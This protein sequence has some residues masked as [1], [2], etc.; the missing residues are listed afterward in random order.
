MT[1]HLRCPAACL[2]ALVA[3]W[4]ARETARR[5]APRAEAAEADAEGARRYRLAALRDE[6]GLIDPR[7]P[8]RARRRLAATLGGAFD[9][10]SAWSRAWL[11]RGPTNRSGRARALVVHPRDPRVMWTATGSGGVWKTTDAGTSW[12]PLTDAIGLPSGCL[13]S[14]PHDADHLYWGTGERYHTGGPGAG[15]WESNDGGETWRVLPSTSAWGY[16]HQIVLS[17]V[18][19]NLI[20]VSRPDSPLITSSG[21]Y[22]STDRGGTWTS[23]LATWGR[24]FDLVLDPS[25]PNRLVT[26]TEDMRPDEP[27]YD[28]YLSTDAGATWIKTNTLT[29][30]STVRYA[31]AFAPSKPS[32]VY[33]LGSKGLL[34]SQDGG[35]TFSQRSGPITLE[36]PVSYATSIWV[37][38][39]DPDILFG[40]G[41]R[42]HRSTDGGA[43]FS[44]VAYESVS[45]EV[46][47]PDHQALVSEPGFD[48]RANSRLYVL[49]DGGIDVIEDALAPAIT[50]ALARGLDA[51]MQTTEV[52]RTA[53]AAHGL[54]LTAVQDSGVL[55]IEAPRTAA[56]D[57]VGGDG[58]CAVVDPQQPAY[59]YGC[60]QGLDIWRFRADGTRIRLATTLPD[61]SVYRIQHS[62]NRSNFLA[63]VLLDPSA[64]SRMLAGGKSLWRSENVRDATDQGPPVWTEIKPALTAPPAFFDA[65]MIL[66]VAIAPSDSNLLFVA[67][68]S[69]LVFR[70]RNG[71]AANPIWEVVD[72]NS[73]RDPLPDRLPLSLLIDREDPARVFVGFGG[74]SAGNLQR[75]TDAGATWRSA[76]GRAG[77]E[78]PEAP[79]WSLAQHPTRPHDFYAG[80]E[81]GVFESADG[82]D[83]WKP[84]SGSAF[85]VAVQDV[86]FVPGTSTLLAGT[87]GRGLWSLETTA[88]PCFF[89]RRL[90]DDPSG[91]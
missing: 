19:P 50:P 81:V 28:L 35:A 48:G 73:S 5:R 74:F 29:A 78:L 9:A 23:V 45:G 24:T 72:D 90:P 2:L 39:L 17:P 4:P 26:E 85:A 64:P 55:G 7:G 16:V 42:L 32:V 1:R 43:T 44:R 38:P 31:L 21:I 86:S 56:S 52:Y 67:H 77:A 49:N 65:N 53:G 34:R 83:T 71:L 27:T 25:N 84:I 60:A 6:H 14:D 30:P 54:V 69:G 10:A 59:A 12:R 91:P 61:S 8:E 76:T 46:G 36:G 22:R 82:G 3:S 79:I 40:G 47:H 51:G 80:T 13:T 68:N 57:L 70:T 75:T 18:D 66:S 11:P 15:I 87:F 37:S 62:D 33:A 41:V 88:G 58:V 89:C 63:P 20:A